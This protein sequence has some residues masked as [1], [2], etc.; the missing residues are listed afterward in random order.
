MKIVLYFTSILCLASCMNAAKSHSHQSSEDLPDSDPFPL[1]QTLGHEVTALK[2]TP[3]DLA[4]LQLDQ[5][6]R[7]FSQDHAAP[8]VDIVN[9]T[10]PP[11]F[12]PN[13]FEQ[14]LLSALYQKRFGYYE[15]AHRDQDGDGVPDFSVDEYL[16]K[17]FEL[18]TDIDGDGIDNY[19]DSDPYDPNK[20]GVDTNGDG[21]PDRD[22]LDVNHNGIPDHVDFAILGRNPEVAAAQ[23]RIFDRYKILLVERDIAFTPSLTQAIEFSLDEVYGKQIA[24][25]SGGARSWIR[26]I[27]AEK[28]VLLDYDESNATYA[29]TD[30]YTKSVVFYEPTVLAAGPIQTAVAVHEFAH[31][32]QFMVDHFEKSKKNVTPQI[33]EKFIDLIKAYGW[34]ITAD[35]QK[36]LPFT[37]IHGFWDEAKSKY[38]FAYKDKTTDEWEKLLSARRQEYTKNPP[39]TGHYLEAADLAP[40]HIVNDYALTSVYEFHSEAATAAFWISVQDRLAVRLAAKNSLPLDMA[41]QKARS[42]MNHILDTGGNYKWTRYDMARGS[43]YLPDFTRWLALSTDTLDHFIDTNHLEDATF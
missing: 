3:E 38:T 39:P 12:A 41:K 10:K 36:P 23:K 16:G 8:L 32:F 4:R 18:D 43:D 1:E 5:L 31:A 29:I 17:F 24:A 13:N 21:I 20:G 30:P 15:L 11:S 28:N 37:A 27:V 2:R 42:I 25:I 22:F 6:S 34:R 26:V 40:Y 33:G 7:I 19:F 9:S 14:A 35:Q